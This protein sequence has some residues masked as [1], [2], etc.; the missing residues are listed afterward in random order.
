[1]DLLGMA[2]PSALPTDALTGLVFGILKILAYGALGVVFVGL[3]MTSFCCLFEG[4]KGSRHQG[5]TDIWR[6]IH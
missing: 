2:D 3:A 5:R 6:L 1:M 4:K